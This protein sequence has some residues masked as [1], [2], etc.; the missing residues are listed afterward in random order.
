[1][2]I[3]RIDNGD[4]ATLVLHGCLDTAAAHEFGEALDGAAAAK[5]LVID[6]ADLEFIAS[7]GIRL[8]VSANKR[9]VVAGG[10]VVLTGMNEVVA[11]V[12]EV[13]GLKDVFTIR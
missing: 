3:E 9:A 1:M 12:F 11:D 2:K 5:E 13:T 8:L 7:S 4:N 10:S 6:F